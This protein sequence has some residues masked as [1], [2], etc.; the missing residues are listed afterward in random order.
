MSLV[1]PKLQRFSFA[2]RPVPVPGDLRLSWRISLILMMLGGSRSNRA[3]LAKLYVLNYAARSDHARAQLDRIIL[4]TE[5]SLNWHMRV[6]P[7]FGRAV[8]F[9]VG[10]RFADW[11]QTAQRAGLQMTKTG[12]DA[13]RHIDEA[14]GVFTEEKRFLKEVGKK[15]TEDFVSRILHLHRA[16]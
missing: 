15:V 3:S 9:V 12:I 13:W 14:E 7:A 5:S 2:S 11:T 1:L 10:E 16:L 8:N 6:E 4:G